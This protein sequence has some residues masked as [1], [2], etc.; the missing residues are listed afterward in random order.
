MGVEQRGRSIQSC[1][2]IDQMLDDVTHDDERKRFGLQTVGLDRGGAYIDTAFAGA[3]RCPPRRLDAHG[4]PSPLVRRNQKRSRP[5]A[6]VHHF[7]GPHEL[8]DPREA[9]APG[10]DLAGLLGERNRI[11]GFP[12]DLS[13]RLNFGWIPQETMAA[14]ETPNN[15]PRGRAKPVGTRTERSAADVAR[16]RIEERFE[17][18][19]GADRARPWSLFQEAA[20]ARTGTF[21]S[22][23]ASY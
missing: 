6:D 2:G 14:G 11:F 3:I 4:F 13:K 8:L 12:I 1:P 19:P 17:S 22:I 16:G 5:T 21:L 9:A 18:I 10:F 23:G 15:V 20:P 7:P